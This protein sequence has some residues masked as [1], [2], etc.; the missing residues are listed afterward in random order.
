MIGHIRGQESLRELPSWWNVHPSQPR[1]THTHP[2]LTCHTAQTTTGHSRDAKVVCLNPSGRVSMCVWGLLWAFLLGSMHVSL[3]TSIWVL[4]VLAA[5]F[6]AY[7]SKAPLTIP[8]EVC[9]APYPRALPGPE[10]LLCSGFHSFPRQETWG[11]EA[12]K[13]DGFPAI[14]PCTSGK[15][16]F[17]LTDTLP[18]LSFLLWIQGKEIFLTLSCAHSA[19]YLLSPYNMP[20]FSKHHPWGFTVHCAYQGQST[21][22]HVLIGSSALYQFQRA[23][24]YPQNNHSLR[25]WWATWKTSTGN[26]QWLQNARESV[27]LREWPQDR[28]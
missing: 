20:I 16:V 15:A 21:N 18:V 4:M 9:T 10:V 3:S 19:T 22:N 27:P 2:L 6:S 25:K 1:S 8:P 14:K 24:S 12:H 23:P 5:A 11:T 17:A 13:S 28:M 7:V 26:R